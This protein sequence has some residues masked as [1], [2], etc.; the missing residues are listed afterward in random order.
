MASATGAVAGEGWGL[1]LTS[2]DGS[3][4]WGISLIAEDW[5]LASERPL[6]GVNRAGFGP[7]DFYQSK[8]MIV[9]TLVTYCL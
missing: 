8:T 4:S 7:L 3:F 2:H 1:S 9:E 6:F 5:D